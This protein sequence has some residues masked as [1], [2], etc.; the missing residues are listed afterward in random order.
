VVA[1]LR[2]GEEVIFLKNEWNE[3]VRAV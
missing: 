3:M 1:A 2:G